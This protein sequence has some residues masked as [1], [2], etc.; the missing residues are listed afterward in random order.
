[1]EPNTHPSLGE[2]A[3]RPDGHASDVAL[4]VLADGEASLLP[5]EV[6]AHVEGC[7]DCSDRLGAAALLSMG[8]TAALRELE[9]AKLAEAARAPSNVVELAAPFSDRARRRSA[10]LAIA[11]ALLV[12]VVSMVPV[13]IGLFSRLPE[14]QRA[15]AR[16]APVVARVA[17]A[18][19]QAATRGNEGTKAALL[20]WLA[21]LF[22]G[23][24]GVQV[25][26]RASRVR[27]LQGGS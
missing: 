2:E 27:V 17:F 6:L 5:R 13:V 25:A 3:W 4:D 22:L 9:P 15:V 24:I 20:W 8:T 7:A 21:A 14:I 10:K 1:M 12:A 18:T 11:A 16:G 23:G 26:R 19:A